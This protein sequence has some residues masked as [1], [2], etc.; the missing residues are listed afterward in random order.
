MGE[1]RLCILKLV[2]NF[3]G[4]YGF[5]RVN[6]LVIARGIFAVLGLINFSFTVSAQQASRVNDFNPASSL[7][8]YHPEIFTSIDS[9]VLIHDLP[10]LALLDGRLP[11]STALGRM[12]MSS[13]DFSSRALLADADYPRTGTSAE[14]KSVAPREVSPLRLSPEFITGEVGFLYGRSTGKHGGDLFGSYIEGTTGNDKF[15]ISVGA[16]YEEFNNHFSRRI[17]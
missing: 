13:V 10:Q 5:S 15:Q 12:G 16:S 11:V 14:Y 1:R 9:S 7:A 4:A 2:Q 6:Y 3:T 8:L 17:R